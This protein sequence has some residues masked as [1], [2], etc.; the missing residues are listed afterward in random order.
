MESLKFIYLLLV[1][2]WVKLKVKAIETSSI[3]S[4]TTAC[5]QQ[6][7]EA[8]TISHLLCDNGNLC[9]PSNLFCDTINHCQDK[10][11]EDPKL[12]QTTIKDYCYQV[13]SHKK[14][15]FP[16]F[17]NAEKLSIKNATVELRI[18]ASMHNVNLRF[19]NKASVYNTLCVSDELVCDYNEHCHSAR[20]ENK[21]IC[22]QRAGPGRSS[23]LNNIYHINNNNHAQCPDPVNQRNCLSSFTECIDRNK[24]C[25]GNFDCSDHS[26]ENFCY[27][28][29]YSNHAFLPEKVCD[30]ENDCPVSD[31]EPLNGQSY[32]EFDCSK[33]SNP[34]STNSAARTGCQQCGLGV[35]CVNNICTEKCS[36]TNSKEPKFGIYY[37]S[38]NKQCQLS[39]KIKLLTHE[40]DRIYQVTYD[41][42]LIH[43]KQLE[44]RVISEQEKFDL[45]SDMHFD[46]KM[47]EV[48][49]FIGKLENRNNIA[50]MSYKYEFIHDQ[51]EIFNTFA[52]KDEDEAKNSANNE[53]LSDF[54]GRKHTFAS[55]KAGDYDIDYR[56]GNI[57][58]N[59]VF[60]QR[61]THPVI[62]QMR[63]DSKNSDYFITRKFAQ[64]FPIIKPIRFSVDPVHGELYVA[65]CLERQISPQ[66]V[67]ILN[68]LG[69]YAPH[70]YIY[71]I[72][73]TG[74][75][76]PKIIA[77]NREE[78][79]LMKDYLRQPASFFKYDE[80]Q[81]A[82]IDQ[83]IN[84]ATDVPYMRTISEMKYDFV[85]ERLY[86]MDHN[87]NTLWS[88]NR[89]G[90]DLKTFREKQI[91]GTGGKFIKTFLPLADN[92]FFITR[93]TMKNQVMNLFQGLEFSTEIEL[94]KVVDKPVSKLTFIENQAVPVNMTNQQYILGGEIVLAAL[95]E[96]LPARID[97]KT[98]GC[99]DF[100]MSD[101][102]T[103]ST[104][105]LCAENFDEKS[106]CATC[107]HGFFKCKNSHQCI[108]DYLV[109][110]GDPDCQD[111]SDE[112]DCQ[113]KKTSNVCPKL[114]M[115]RCD[116][117]NKATDKDHECIQYREICDGRK[118]CE[119]GIDED[120]DF[121]KDFECLPGYYKCPSENKCISRKFICDG[122]PQCKNAEDEQGCSKYGCH[123]K[124]EF[125]CLSKSKT[126][127]LSE[128][129]R[130]QF[131]N[132]R[133]DQNA[134]T[135][136]WACVK[137]EKICDGVIDCISG[138]DEQHCDSRTTDLGTCDAHQFQCGDGSCIDSYL[139]CNNFFNCKDKSDENNCY[140]GSTE[141]CPNNYFTCKSG[142]IR[143]QKCIPLRYKCDGES[144]C[145]DGSDEQDCPKDDNPNSINNI[146][147]NHCTDNQYRCMLG[148]CIDLSKKCDKKPDCPFGDD[149]ANCPRSD[150][151][152]KQPLQNCPDSKP[153]S[154]LGKD[155]KV[156]NIET[157]C[158]EN[159][160]KC[161]GEQFCENGFDESKEVCNDTKCDLD[162]I[163]CMNDGNYVCIDDAKMCDGV[164]DCDD[165][166]DEANCPYG[167]N[168]RS[169]EDITR[170]VH[171]TFTCPKPMKM[172]GTPEN[173]YQMRYAMGS[174]LVGNTFTCMDES[175]LC[176]SKISC[177]TSQEDERHCNSGPCDFNNNQCEAATEICINLKGNSNQG[178]SYCQ[179]KS[180][181]I[182]NQFNFGAADI[183]SLSSNA[184]ASTLGNNSTT[185][186]TSCVNINECKSAL[187]CSQLCYDLPGSYRCGCIDPN[188][189]DLTSG[190][191]F[192]PKQGSEEN[193]RLCKYKDRDFIL[194]LRIN[195]AV[196]SYKKSKNSEA[197]YV[198]IDQNRYHQLDAHKNSRG[199]AYPR[200]G[201]FGRK[202]A[203]LFKDNE[204][205][206]GYHSYSVKK[207]Y[208]NRG[209]SSS[210]FNTETLLNYTHVLK[211]FGPGMTENG[212]ELKFIQK[213][214]LGNTI[215][216][217][218]IDWKT[219]AIYF[220]HND[221][222]YISTILKSNKGEEEKGENSIGTH[223]MSNIIKFD[224]PISSA[225]KSSLR[226]CPIQA[227][228]FYI[229]KQANSKYQ[230]IFQIQLLKSL[231]D[232][233]KVVAQHKMLS[234]ND[235]SVHQDYPV[236]F[237]IDKLNK[238]RKAKIAVDPV[239]CRLYITD[240]KHIITLDSNRHLDYEIIPELFTTLPKELK[241]IT[242]KLDTM[243]VHENYLYFLGD[244][245][246]ME[247]KKQ[248]KRKRKWRRNRRNKDS[249]TH[250][251]LYRI[252]RLSHYSHP[253]VVMS[254]EN[255]KS[256]D[257]TVAVAITKPTYN[258]ANSNC[259][260]GCQSGKFCIGVQSLNVN[261][262][263]I[264]KNR[265]KDLAQ[266][267]RN[268]LLFK[269]ENRATGYCICGDNSKCD[270][271]DVQKDCRL[272][273]NGRNKYD[274]CNK[275]DL[276][277]TQC[278]CKDGYT[279]VECEIDIRNTEKDKNQED[280]NKIDPSQD[281]VVSDNSISDSQKSDN[282]DNEN[283]VSKSSLSQKIW[284][285]VGLII[286]IALTIGI[287]LFYFK[288]KR[289]YLP[290]EH[291]TNAQEMENIWNHNLDNVDNN[292]QVASYNEFGRFQ[293]NR[294]HLDD[295]RQGLDYDNDH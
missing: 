8:K 214:E 258:W 100:V 102:N 15:P 279:G 165:N 140:I 251:N 139:V 215:S 206:S 129:E 256:K 134:T 213:L 60:S 56:T 35:K 186:K 75:S 244:W 203:T 183:G 33:D 230:N 111:G 272:R 294:D 282:A 292:T 188:F 149:E 13:V 287:T 262:F 217:P 77:I 103:G 266:D 105:C 201:L 154:C 144:D 21:N 11:D 2:Y 263:E 231:N 98:A 83:A 67:T 288:R 285:I 34:F 259:D 238:F 290:V 227:K 51:G 125:A 96:A 236:K 73:L 248:N 250:R 187:T 243:F 48:Y 59:Q 19:Q 38:K 12:C 191:D 222:V 16:C 223:Q 284:L 68:L 212:N 95:S 104:S 277:N 174:K 278:D 225:L 24:F 78:T 106:N 93:P 247:Q 92:I 4:D 43:N 143:G 196:H 168:H 119:N 163:R 171:N 232:Q 36:L 220:L 23:T 178:K 162:Q 30:G 274:G 283:F 245:T 257:D 94:F 87:I 42:N 109:C 289:K 276:G 123:P 69:T 268:Q 107:K 72:P 120:P 57:Y 170:D 246:D 190:A 228:L 5:Q 242:G 88:V 264:V 138:H 137:N 53:L 145:S 195:N 90:T 237:N 260:N 31:Q 55:M 45:M 159:I 150:P 47:K 110:D 267:L 148:T 211:A 113:S 64:G 118:N 193:F 40:N 166:Q 122:I 281:Q 205:E 32:D 116:K 172:V 82:T 29:L 141:A 97:P 108:R 132:L 135:Y 269:S 1:L 241:I 219:N 117:E 71:K 80:Q 234:F 218:V 133:Y 81:E 240:G 18:K 208:P 204:S 41:K 146:M 39:D 142:R 147:N 273:C 252:N 76:E 293:V 49:A 286:I 130:L 153:N 255:S 62:Y 9:I 275:D 192:Q 115:F 58:M 54:L 182:R 79:K 25:D 270:D 176:D 181:Y 221:G 199:V 112:D 179:C 127:S 261:L 161:N 164:Q 194:N 229:Q 3:Y 131:R 254:L 37:D 44:I 70:C 265:N 184:A 22:E 189:F 180:G 128:K 121:C 63:V 136:H 6:Q 233:H 175:T 209:A 271:S 20:D 52:R 66:I 177:T 50:D 151:P 200:S 291:N 173:G 114:G 169:L 46:V 10:A 185:T 202:R 197:D 253:E 65:D 86:F 7:S 152:K 160:E 126:G 61:F 89:D 91:F 28:C 207:Y 235:L 17:E 295:D 26:D 249:F 158:F 167:C 74:K 239:T 155:K 124:T 99:S 85:S 280:Q 216:T 27:P 210:N 84:Q 14:D 157:Q 224:S 198:P 156:E 226:I 101:N